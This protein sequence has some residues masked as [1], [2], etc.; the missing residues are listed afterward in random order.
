M[1]INRTIYRAYHNLSETGEFGYIGK[2][3]FQDSMVLQNPDWIEVKFENSERTAKLYPSQIGDIY[4]GHCNPRFVT[5]KAYQKY[6]R[7][8]N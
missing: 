1:N 3:K 7:G 5:L 8:E 6:F 2:S 4:R